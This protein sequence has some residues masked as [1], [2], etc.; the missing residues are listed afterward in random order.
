VRVR[1]AV[2]WWAWVSTGRPSSAH[3]SRTLRA[4]AIFRAVG[5]A[6]AGI[7]LPQRLRTL[8]QAH[9]IGTVVGKG[10]LPRASVTVT[11]SGDA[12]LGAVGEGARG[13]SRKAGSEF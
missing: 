5:R 4:N 6:V 12:L 7:E 8:P 1:R 11:L 10:S 2:D 9:P 13:G 3:L